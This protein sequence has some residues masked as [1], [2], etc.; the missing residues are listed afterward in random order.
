MATLLQKQD[1]WQQSIP[2]LEAA[3][4]SKSDYAQAHYR[5]ALAFSHTGRKSEANNEVVLQQRYRQQE[6]QDIDA[7]LNEVTTLL[8]N[9]K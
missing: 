7:K 6:S 1:Q 5:L 8:V 4:R 9:M 2:D 3:I